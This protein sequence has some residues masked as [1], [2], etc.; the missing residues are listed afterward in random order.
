MPAHVIGPSSRSYAIGII[1]LTL[2]ILSIFE[3]FL[4][5]FMSI[6]RLVLIVLLV[7]M[8]GAEFLARNAANVPESLGDPVEV[9]DE[10]DWVYGVN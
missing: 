5:F 3:V 1:L 4:S 10:D 8:A 6:S 9:E 7:C 2:A